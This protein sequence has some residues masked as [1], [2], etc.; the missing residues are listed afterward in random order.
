MIDCDGLIE[1]LHA[2][3]K[4]H[5]HLATIAEV[6]PVAEMHLDLAL[7]SARQA[8]VAERLCDDGDRPMAS[9]QEGAVRTPR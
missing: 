7:F 3:A 5:V 8:Q 6:V 2:E 9:D 4:S 1:Q